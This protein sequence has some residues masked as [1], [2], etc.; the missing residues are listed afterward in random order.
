MH[1]LAKTSANP[2]VERVLREQFERWASGERVSAEEFF[3]RYPGLLDCAEDTLDVIVAEFVLREEL[4][5]APT[6]EEFLSRFPQFQ[7]PLRRHIEL[8]HALERTTPT[9]AD[10]YRPVRRAGRAPST[11]AERNGIRVPGYEILG[12][13]GRGGMGVVYK[14]QHTTLRRTVALKLLAHLSLARPEDAARFQIEGEALASLQHPHV[15]RLYEVGEWRNSEAMTIPFLAMEFVEGGSLDRVLNGQPQSPRMA[16][17][18]VEKL[19]R[20]AHAAHQ[21]GVIH[22]DL[23]PANI[24]L[25]ADPEARPT[26]GAGL[27]HPTPADDPPSQL[28]DYEPK[29]SD[30]G[31]ARILHRDPHLTQTGTMLGTPSYIAPEQIEGSPAALTPACDVY[32]LG[33]ILFELL[34]GK[35]PFTAATPLRLLALV[36]SEEPVPPSSRRC[37]PFD[38]D[39]ICLKCLRKDPRQRYASAEALADD[40]RRFRAGEPIRARPT[41]FWERGWKWARRRPAAAA[42]IGVIGLALLSLAGGGLWYQKQLQ[43]ALRTA[44]RERDRATAGYRLARQ[45]VDEYFT[46]VSE[47]KLL[48]KDSLQP[49]RKDLLT[50]ALKYYQEFLRQQGDDPT[51]RAEL[52]QAYQRMAWITNAIGSKEEALAAY[53]K[54]RDAF[55][56]LSH[57]APCDPTYPFKWASCCDMIGRLQG[58]TG[59]PADALRSHAQALAVWD[60]LLKAQPAEPCWKTSWANNRMYSGFIHRQMGQLNEALRAYEEAQAMRAQLV[61]HQPGDLYFEGEYATGHIN[62]GSVLELLDRPAEAVRSYEQARVLFEQLARRNSTEEAFLR[63]GVAKSCSCLANA[64]AALGK[65]EEALRLRECAR[66]HLE[67]LVQA[68]PSV[69]D[70]QRELAMTYLDLARLERVSGRWQAAQRAGQRAHDLWNKLVQANPT[71]PSL[72]EKL[73]TSYADLGRCRHQGGQPTAAVGDFEQARRIGAQLVQDHPKEIEF[74]TS[75]VATLQDLGRLC[76]DLRQPAQAQQA[77]TEAQGRCEKLV[78]AQPGVPRYRCCLAN[79]YY[80]IG[81]FHAAYHRPAEALRFH[82]QGRGLLDQLVRTRP[83]VVAFQS[84]LAQSQ[85]EVGNAHFAARHFAEAIRCYERARATAANILQAHPH[86]VK[87]LGT[88]GIAWGNR[89]VILRRLGQSEEALEA[90]RQAVVH[91]R[92]AVNYAPQAVQ[93]RRWLS[94][95]YAGS[96]A[97]LR[98][99][100]R[101][102]DASDAIEERRQLWPHDVRRQLVAAW[103][104][105]QCIP[106][107]GQG[108]PDLSPEDLRQQQRHAGRALDAFRQALKC[109]GASVLR[110]AENGVG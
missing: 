13:L 6:F 31:L 1:E 4:G 83:A 54:A 56:E 92:R 81:L 98:D 85:V 21:R 8:E 90:F 102:S 84:Y 64:H 57:S 63:F 44:E 45:A 20:A 41:P 107:V 94:N 35:P 5:E 95:H 28:G 16:A 9:E 101:P 58:E 65:S 66:E 27:A 91:Q 39:S 67:Q 49:L 62:V 23:K 106:L 17:A 96:A 59:R 34:T 53:E 42:L 103:G 50:A 25:A 7:E 80:H 69:T 75:L 73:A 55:A 30:F 51:L 26:S 79:V 109:L 89:G 87:D 48:G 70:Y 29:I 11:P 60:A 61:Q 104:F 110:S 36:R 68:N 100:H 19:A 32:A 93:Y 52:A 2:L 15:V 3:H 88:L 74:Q 108:K 24:L 76:V 78:R 86:R 18:F 37:I 46:Q 40:L 22:R 105:V 97:A 38:L 72:Q 77:Y 47:S 82:E 71:V 43:A 12:E 10:G 33:A 14:A 99:L